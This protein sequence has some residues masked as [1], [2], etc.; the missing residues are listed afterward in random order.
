VNSGQPLTQVDLRE[1]LR[2]EAAVELEELLIRAPGKTF[3]GGIRL[4]VQEWPRKWAPSEGQLPV[5]TSSEVDSEDV[6]L[7]S[8]SF[9]SWLTPRQTQMVGNDRYI[10]KGFL[11]FSRY[12]LQRLTNAF[13]LP[14]GYALD[15]LGEIGIPMR[16]SWIDYAANDTKMAAGT[17]MGSSVQESRSNTLMLIVSFD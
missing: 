3:L 8:D 11:P 2:H 14:K 13:H 9:V 7:S 17:N 5:D 1:Y 15:L 6:H 12:T 16:L 4:L 10:A